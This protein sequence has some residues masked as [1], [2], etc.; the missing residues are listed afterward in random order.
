MKMWVFSSSGIWPWLRSSVIWGFTG[1]ALG[2]L[3]PEAEHMAEVANLNSC[4]AVQVL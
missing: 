2:S 1:L 4:R 3:S